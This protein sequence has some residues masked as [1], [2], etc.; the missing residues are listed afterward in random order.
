MAR[1]P[2]RL[3]VGFN[4]L[5]AA[6]VAVLLLQ[7]LDVVPDHEVDLARVREQ[8]F[9]LSDRFDER[10]VLGEQ[11]VPLELVENE[12]REILAEGRAEALARCAG[13]LG[14]AP[15][16]VGALEH[17]GGG[18]VQTVSAMALLVVDEHLGG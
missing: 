18:R 17:G 4:D 16:A 3:G 6:S 10:F 5:G 2:A 1:A 8:V 11:R 13:D 9:E 14:D 15:A 7:L 12:P